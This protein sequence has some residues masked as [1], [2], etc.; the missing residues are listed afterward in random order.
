MQTTGR[1]ESGLRFSRTV[2]AHE[3]GAAPACSSSRPHP[4]GVWSGHETTAAAQVEVQTEQSFNSPATG[5]GR[6]SR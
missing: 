6:D 5:Q 1:L 3:A 4:E 2:V